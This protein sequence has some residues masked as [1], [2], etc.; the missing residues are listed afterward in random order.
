MASGH[1]LHLSNAGAEAG[2]FDRAA[3]ASCGRWDLVYQLLPASDADEA[4][5][6]TRPTPAELQVM[7]PTSA[8]A[9]APA[10]NAV[11]FATP[12]PAATGTGLSSSAP[13]RPRSADA[14]L[15]A[16]ARWC[17]DEP[18]PSA[19]WR[20]REQCG[21][22][23]RGRRGRGRIRRRGQQQQSGPRR[24]AAATR[25]GRRAREAV[26]ADFDMDHWVAELRCVL[27]VGGRGA[28][29]AAVGGGSGDDSA[30][31]ASALASASAAAAVGSGQGPYFSSS[32]VDKSWS[33]ASRGV[34]R[35]RDIDAENLAASVPSWADAPLPSLKE[36][37]PIG[38]REETEPALKSSST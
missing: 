5:H 3:F 9:V 14:L 8:D 19:F 11:A 20:S 34:V 32:S 17:G 31:L 21:G 33:L 6:P 1:W 23:A 7:P 24:V 25:G 12:S 30:D 36:S 13:R 15:T 16:R 10:S 38:A 4:R 22:A 37:L 2:V 27:E 35:V 26:H 29:V 18:P 28:G